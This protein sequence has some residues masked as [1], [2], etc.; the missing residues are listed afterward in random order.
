[1]AMLTLLSATEAGCVSEVASDTRRDGRGKA[2][3]KATVAWSRAT[4]EFRRRKALLDMMR[5]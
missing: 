2:M 4:R 5:V 3:T 1:M